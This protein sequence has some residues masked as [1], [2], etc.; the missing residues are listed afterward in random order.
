LLASSI[1]TP[2]QAVFVETKQ[3]KKKSV[4]KDERRE[5]IAVATTTVASSNEVME[6]NEE[7]L[8]Q[9]ERERNT[10]LQVDKKTKR[11]K[12][13]QKILTGNNVSKDVYFSLLACFLNYNSRSR[14]TCGN[15]QKRGERSKDRENR[16][17]DDDDDSNE[18]MDEN[19]EPLHQTEEKREEDQKKPKK[20]YR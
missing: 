5:K 14:C 18:V 16:D 12:K 13:N 9:T 4:E 7:P 1:T 6:E 20:T 10:K 8:H 17:N 2:A 3:K 11:E 19:E 15:E